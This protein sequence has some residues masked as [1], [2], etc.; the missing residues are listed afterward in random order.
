MSACSAVYDNHASFPFAG[1]MRFMG[2][3]T[4]LGRSISF[5]RR[6]KTSASRSVYISY[7]TYLPHVGCIFKQHVAHLSRA[8]RE[9]RSLAT[10]HPPILGDSRR[11]TEAIARNVRRI[12]VA[13]ATFYFY[14]IIRRSKVF[15]VVL[16]TLSAIVKI[17]RACSFR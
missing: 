7:E 13:M 6:I 4:S 15:H 12:D 16:F 11:N 1:F 5:D 17:S 9:E 2:L 8:S 14:A 3:F 10:C